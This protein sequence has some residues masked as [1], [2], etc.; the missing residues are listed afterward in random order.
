MTKEQIQKRV[1]ELAKD[2]EWNHLYVL[3]HGVKTRKGHVNSPGFNTC[4][5]D[6]PRSAED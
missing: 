4:F 3:S 1:L 6:R 5:R 2:E